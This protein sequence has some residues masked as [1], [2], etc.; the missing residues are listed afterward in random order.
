MRRIRNALAT[1]ILALGALV[2]PA[3]AFHKSADNEAEGNAQFKELIRQRELERKQSRQRLMEKEQASS[4]PKKMLVRVHER[5]DDPTS[6]DGSKVIATIEMT[7]E[8]VRNRDY[9]R[10]IA[11]AKAHQKAHLGTAAQAMDESRKPLFERETASPTGSYFNL[12]AVGLLGLA[13]VG[14]WV[15]RPTQVT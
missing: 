13:A 6:R 2:L 3:Q 1:L 14:W 4:E 9:K 5:G 15:M 8:E 7:P 11:K 12:I 10:M